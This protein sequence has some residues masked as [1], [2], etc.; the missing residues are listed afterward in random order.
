MIA[1]L[2]G[3]ITQDLSRRLPSK[4]RISILLSWTGELYAQPPES[5]QI[6]FAVRSRRICSFS[7]HNEVC[8]YVAGNDF[9]GA[10]VGIPAGVARSRAAG[11]RYAVGSGLAVG[12]YTDHWRESKDIDFYVGPKDRELMQRILTEGDWSIAQ[13]PPFIHVVL[14]VGHGPNHVHNY[15]ALDR[16]VDPGAVVRELI[17]ISRTGTFW[18]TVATNC[19]ESGKKT[20][21]QAKACSTKQASF[22]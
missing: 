15:L 1:S 19:G 14:V 20:N 9:R 22:D 8:P 17:V 11:L 5:Q 12:V 7:R 6:F 4:S 21:E 2:G 16:P 13:H 10:V 18:N 3:A